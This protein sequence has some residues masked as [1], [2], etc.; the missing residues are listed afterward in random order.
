MTRA[1]FRILNSWSQLIMDMNTT[2]NS[3]EA[4][5]R[6]MLIAGMA[7]LHGRNELSELDVT[8]IREAD[9]SNDTSATQMT[10]DQGQENAN[11]R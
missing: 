11:Q 1:G 10:N 4:L 3:I 9:D 8:S 6:K 2:A 7:G 5:R